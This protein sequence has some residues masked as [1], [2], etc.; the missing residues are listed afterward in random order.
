MRWAPLTLIR[1]ILGRSRLLVI[2]RL[3]DTESI[4]VCL[5]SYPV[6]SSAYC[7]IG[8]VYKVVNKYNI[9][10]RLEW[11]VVEIMVISV[12]GIDLRSHI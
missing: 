1:N 2:W 12:S 3:P 8:V 11:D 7:A 6:D 5:G 9:R 10:R 4:L